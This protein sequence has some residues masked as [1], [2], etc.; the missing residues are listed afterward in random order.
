MTFPFE[1]V[2]ENPEHHEGENYKQSHHTQANQKNVPAGKQAE[3]YSYRDEDER[4]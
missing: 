2:D 3:Y 1:C 4:K